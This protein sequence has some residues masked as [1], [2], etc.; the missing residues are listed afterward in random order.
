MVGFN[1]RFSP[2]ARAVRGAFA[3][4]RAPMVVTYRV[5][6]GVVPPDSW[7]ADPAEGG[8]VVGEVCHF[9]D[10]STA[11]IGREPAAVT[12]HRVASPRPDSS[13][14]SVVMTIRYDDGSLATIQYVAAGDR[15]LA[16]ERCE[17]F[18][19][20]RA[21]V[22]DDFRTT[23]FYGGGRNVRGRQAKGFVEELRAFVDACRHGGPWPIPWP[24]VAG[25]HRVCF[26]ALRSLE[27]GATVPVRVGSS[28]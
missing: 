1:R 16:K 22:L 6:A 18:A 19:D 21:A 13:G 10:L 26:G 24:D 12:A 11:L 3:D 8:R 23:R 25:A 5:N 28:A 27:T 2:H 14:D 17:V 20:G 4:R 9:V 15:R 7:L